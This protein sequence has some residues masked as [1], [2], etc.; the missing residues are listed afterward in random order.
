MLFLRR[1]IGFLTLVTIAVA[2]AAQSGLSTR[3][4]NRLGQQEAA[5]I[6]PHAAED[7]SGMYSFLKEGEF[8]QINL[9]KAAVTGYISRMGVSD[10]DSGVFMDQFFAQADVQD[11]AVSFTTRQ[12]HGTWYEF[13]GK[14]DRGSA[15]TKA[16]DGYY[17][18][19]GTLKELSTNADKSI[20]TRSRE[21]EFKL[22][23]QPDDSDEAAPVKDKKPK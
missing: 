4:Q 6:I 22:L 18:L 2:C 13:K 3:G 10:S 19:R 21:V 16:D 17:V 15:R 23:A 7:I 20:A 5:P 1:I 9:E 8:V 14:F 12:L 11:H